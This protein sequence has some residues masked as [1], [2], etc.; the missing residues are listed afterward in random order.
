[1]AGTILEQT[2][3]VDETNILASECPNVLSCGTMAAATFFARE[4]DSIRDC[5]RPNPE[6]VT[7]RL[8]YLGPQT[9][10][11]TLLLDL[12][13]TLVHTTDEAPCV[14]DIDYCTFAVPLSASVTPT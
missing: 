13:E 1:M 14:F 8:V 2:V 5:P 11:Y 12:D 3:K 9:K 4:L 6:D 7:A 10:K